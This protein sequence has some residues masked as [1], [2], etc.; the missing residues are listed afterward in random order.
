MKLTSS[1]HSSPPKQVENVK[2]AIWEL[3]EEQET[4][5]VSSK[6]RA[7]VPLPDE[8]EEMRCL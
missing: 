1:L 7:E 3:E 5:E 8:E 2:K 6:R 4:S